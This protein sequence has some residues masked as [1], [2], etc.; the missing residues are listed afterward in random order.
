MGHI[1][2][3]VSVGNPSKTL[4]DF[5]CFNYGEEEKGK[6][7]EKERSHIHINIHTHSHI[8]RSGLK[9]EIRNYLNIGDHGSHVEDEVAVSIQ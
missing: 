5:N 6:G 8:H 3:K 2:C 9:R 1:E 7:R 4:L